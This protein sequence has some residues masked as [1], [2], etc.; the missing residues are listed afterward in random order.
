MIDNVKSPKHYKLDG[1]N[2]E[3]KDVA[4]AVIKNIKNTKVAVCVFNVLKYVMRA[5]KKNGIEDYKKAIEY[6]RYIIEE[7]ENKVID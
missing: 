5:E 3:V 4:F 7:K 2:I 6:L 1:L